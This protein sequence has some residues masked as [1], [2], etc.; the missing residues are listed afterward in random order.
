M[1]IREHTF[2]LCVCVCVVAIWISSFLN[3]LLI[4][5]CIFQLGVC[6]FFF[7]SIKKIYIYSGYEPFVS[8]MT[9]D[10]FFRFLP[11]HSHNDAFWS[12]YQFPFIASALDVLFVSE[13]TNFIWK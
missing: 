12:T 3:F 2:T 4:P 9:A 8:N 11:F 7:F 5:L 13:K 1:K 6:V 10:I